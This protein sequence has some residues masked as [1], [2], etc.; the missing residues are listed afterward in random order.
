MGD[1][2]RH[3]AALEPVPRVVAIL[4]V[5]SEAQLDGHLLADAEVDRGGAHHS[6]R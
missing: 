6:E 5:G 4:G 2:E 3:L 1:I